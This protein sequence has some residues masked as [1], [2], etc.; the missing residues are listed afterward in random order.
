MSILSVVF[1]W[2]DNKILLIFDR[3][4]WLLLFIDVLVKLILS[5]NEIQYILKNL[6]DIIAAIHTPRQYLSL[7][8]NC[9]SSFDR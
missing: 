3:I 5:K 2:S 8:S 1:I 4:V 9:E 6:F 7:C